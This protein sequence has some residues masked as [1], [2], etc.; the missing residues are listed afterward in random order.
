MKV[1]YVIY[2]LVW[3]LRD[4]S[5]VPSQIPENFSRSLKGDNFGHHDASYNLTLRA[6]SITICRCNRVK[7]VQSYNL[8]SARAAIRTRILQRM[9]R[10]LGNF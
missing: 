7:T 2:N 3:R 4:R 9:F 1:T 10:N 6:L 5:T 8:K